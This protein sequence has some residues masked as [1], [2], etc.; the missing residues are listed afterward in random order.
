MGLHERWPEVRRLFQEA[1]DRDGADREAFL[2]SVPEGPVLDE[3][4]SLLD[5]HAPETGFL[6]TPATVTLQDAAASVSDSL[7]GTTLGPW[8]I[9]GRIG[10]G[11][12]GVV[13]RAVR[14]DAAFEREV[15]LKVIGALRQSPAGVERFRLERETLARLDHPAIARLLD[16]GTTPGGDPYFVMELVDGVPVDRYCDQQA[17]TIGQRLDVFLRICRGVQYAHRNLVVHRDLKPDN[18]LVLADGSPKLLDFGVA[19]LLAG[20]GPAGP[21]DA[22][23]ASSTWALTPDF[24]SPE[25][26]SGALVTTASDVYAL[27]VLL[28]LLLT[29]V[30]PYRLRP[31][32]RSAMAATLS[33]IQIAPPSVQV[34]D[35]DPLHAARRKTTPAALRRTLR[36]DLDAISLRALAAD[37][38]DRYP[39]VDELMHDLQRYRHSRPVHA[40]ARTPLYVATRLV[41]RHRLAVAASVIAAV[42]VAAGVAGILW[43]SGIAREA[44]ARAERRFDDL[45]D[46]THVFMFD[47][48]DAILNVPGTTDARALMVRTGIQYLERLAGEAGPDRSLRRELAAGFVKVGDAQGNPS[49][50]NIGDSAGALASYARAIEIA[51]GLLAADPTDIDAARTLALAH[52]RLGDVRAWMGS[53]DTALSHAEASA[54]RFAEIARLAGATTEDRLQAVIGQIKLGDLLGNPNLPNLG[55][56]DEAMA[57]YDVAR[58]AVGALAD[59]APQDQRVRRYVGLTYER[60]GSIHQLASRWTE[61]GAAYR[62]SFAIRE[63]LAEAAPVHVDIQRDLAIAYEKLANV[64]R[65]TGHPESAVTY[66]RGALARFQRL[67]TLDAANANATRSVAI[68]REHLADLLLDLGQSRAAVTE[69]QAALAGHRQLAVGDTSNAQAPC[70]TARVADRLGI[71]MAGGAPT[72]AACEAWR[73]AEQMRRRRAADGCGVSGDEASDIARRLSWCAPQGRGGR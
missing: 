35:S 59:E 47:V 56:P 68:S 30:L 44:Q 52:R 14:A 19:K 58:A 43:Q 49:S 8:R 60:I 26:V 40:R 64:E 11:G 7:L 12:M 65:R 17:L 42:L 41:G 70:D 73:D 2:A 54:T 18:I 15:A 5:W 28:H 20:A 37:P 57:R 9:V 34:R 6:E 66:A 31:E 48:H 67:A 23:L 10:A 27:G 39:T 51:G 16:G 21:E 46:M 61:A 4:R 25:Q 38:A 36:G 1:S 29:G 50:P 71:L 32:P 55:R 69:L 24:A 62:E 45:R 63:A 3:V 72:A 53:K 33:R 13:Y 22:A